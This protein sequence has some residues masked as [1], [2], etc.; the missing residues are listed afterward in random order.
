VGRL[1]PRNCPHPKDVLAGI[2]H[3]APDNHRSF[4]VDREGSSQLADSLQWVAYAL[5]LIFIAQVAFSLFPIALT[6]PSWLGRASEGLRGTASL[7]MLA[8]AMLMLANWIDEDVLP[9]ARHL[10]LI[11]RLSTYVAIGYLLLIPVQSYAS[12]ATIRSQ[13][14]EIQAPVAKM[15]EATK[16]IQQ[17]NTEEQLRAAIRMLPNGEE[18][19]SRPLG[20][21]VPILKANMLARLRPAAKRMEN[22]LKSAQ[23]AAFNNT[24]YP[25]V[26]DAVICF[27]HALGFAAMGFS[28]LGRPTPLRRLIRPHSA[29]LRIRPLGAKKMEA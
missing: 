16:R 23:N 8:V 24:V 14:Q 13:V 19:A 25:L 6:Q 20:A 3:D 4:R 10:L 26:K 29:I 21:E 9:S 2:R 27:A 11:R 15:V 1:H 17:A 22:E 28:G 12:F 7:P 5:L 18:L